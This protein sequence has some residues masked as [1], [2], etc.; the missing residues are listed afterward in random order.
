M[1][2]RARTATVGLIA[3]VAIPALAACSAPAPAGSS[4][5]SGSSA[6][7]T[8]QIT[9]FAAASLT[10]VM[11]TLTD[12]YHQE[13]PGVQFTLSYA[14]SS[15]LVPQLTSGASADVLVTADEASIAAIPQNTILAPG[16]TIIASNEIALAVAP[17]NPGKIGSLED[18]S[19]DS[20]IAVC[21]PAVPCGRA[22]QRV[23]DAAKLSLNGPSQENAV[24]AVLTKAS[25]GQVDAG[26][27]YSTDVKAAASQGLTSVKLNDPSPNKYPMALTTA[28]AKK[29]E[30][31]GFKT[32][33]AG[34]EAAGILAD[35]GFGPGSASTASGT[36][37][38]K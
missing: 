4:Q 30:V 32:W 6:A 13:T 3:A 28:A 7:A 15:Q 14:A 33:L 22:A 5:A 37:S 29:P 18:A 2:Y 26:F 38:G 17:G 24:R 21:A 16:T 23:L 20:K 8:G 12:K 1:T 35:A 27:V 9:V 11:K 25:A 19:K 36:A 31:L 34:P 10:D